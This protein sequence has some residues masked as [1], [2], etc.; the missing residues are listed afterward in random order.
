MYRTFTY[1]GW[2]LWTYKSKQ[3]IPISMTVNSNCGICRRSRYC[4]DVPSRVNGHAGEEKNFLSLKGKTVLEMLTGAL[5]P[6]KASYNINGEIISSSKTKAGH[7]GPWSRLWIW[8]ISRWI[9]IHIRNSSGCQ[10]GP[11]T[12]F[13]MNF[14]TRNNKSCVSI[15]LK[16][17]FL[18]SWVGLW[19]LIFSTAQP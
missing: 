11:W 15:P 4:S 8:K 2:D 19:A 1:A 6:F 12:F 7:T 3:S 14:E 9:R 16:S 5:V 13:K 17:S 10:L 18:P